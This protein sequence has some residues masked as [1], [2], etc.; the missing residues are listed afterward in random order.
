MSRQP[1]NWGEFARRQADAPPPA[2][3]RE[4]F[5][6]ICARLLN[7]ADGREFMR[8][9]YEMHVDRRCR[10]GASEAELREAEAK[11]ALVAEIEKARDEGLTRRESR[12]KN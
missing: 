3:A 1:P 9:L 11:R 8:L 4:D 5:A 12:T 10:P 7:G 6:D 2:T